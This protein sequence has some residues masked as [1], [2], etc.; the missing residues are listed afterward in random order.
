MSEEEKI[1]R[2]IFYD[3]KKGRELICN[4]KEC[5]ANGFPHRHNVTTCNSHPYCIDDR[6]KQQ[7]PI[8]TRVPWPLPSD[9]TFDKKHYHGDIESV[10][11]YNRPFLKGVEKE[12]VKK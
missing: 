5:L 9:V 2:F 8:E 7:S 4:K 6:M 12:E 10:I 3:T 11:K 1:H